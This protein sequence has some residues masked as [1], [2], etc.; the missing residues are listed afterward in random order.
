MAK[1]IRLKISGVKPDYIIIGISC[2]L[3]DY[4]IIYRI[5]QGLNFHF[6]K[7]KDLK[8]FPDKKENFASFSL[9]HFYHTDCL[10]NYYF[11]S[12]HHPEAKL[13]AGLKQADYFLFIH[14]VFPEEEKKQ[15]IKKLSKIKD[16]LAVF[17]VNPATLKQ[18]DPVLYDLELHMA[19][20][21]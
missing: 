10:I 21:G 18:L 9:Y 16:I 1:K 6:K 7:L 5:N 2:H 11:I 4:R 20:I 19:E 13:I 8:I 15:L 14:G 12:N 17:D 3:R